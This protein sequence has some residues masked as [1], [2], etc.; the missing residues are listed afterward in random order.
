MHLDLSS[1]DLSNIEHDAFAILHE[2]RT[3]NLSSN[4]LDDLTLNLTNS[5]E[6]L[7]IASNKL[8]YWP[9]AVYPEKLQTLELQN[10]R[11]IELFYT[12]LGKKDIEFSNIVQINVSHNHIEAIPSNLQYPALKVL[13]L[14]FNRFSELPQ[15][16]GRQAPNLDWLRLNG[17]PIQKIEFTQ[18][19]F[20]RK[21]ELSE[22]SLLSELDASQFD[23]IG[24]P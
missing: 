18:K 22:L 1:N 2:L 4:I 9:L 12:A 14:S 8:Q 7:M 17:N 13:D 24:R 3:L 11:L 5:L 21:L 23:W 6:H 20:T 19:M 16:L 15:T 10:N